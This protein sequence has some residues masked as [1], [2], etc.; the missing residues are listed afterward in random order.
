MGAELGFEV[1]ITRLD[2]RADHSGEREQSLLYRDW[3]AR[4]G[5]EI[6]VAFVMSSE[7]WGPSGQIENEVAFRDRTVLW[8]LEDEGVAACRIGLRVIVDADF[9]RTKDALQ[10]CMILP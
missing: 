1:D 4:I 7:E 5:T 3:I 9:E 10:S 6:A 8:P 2:E